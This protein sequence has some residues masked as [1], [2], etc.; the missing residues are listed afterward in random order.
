LPRII[1][2]ARA[3]ELFFAAETIDAATALQWG[4]VS[5][6]VP[7]GA[8]MSEAHAL[9]AKISRQPP[10]VLRMAKKLMHEGASAN[11]ETVMDM[12][13]G[14]QTLAH[15]SEDHAEALAAFFEKR[16]PD[17]KGR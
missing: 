13:A 5:K 10:G 15:A 4:L 9:A 14:F 12:S 11:F 16:D 3:A 2:H 8:L 1:G 7:S 6:V 17:F